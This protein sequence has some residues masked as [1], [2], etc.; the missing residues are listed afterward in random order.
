MVLVTMVS[1]VRK[2]LSMVYNLMK[3]A[4]TRGPRG[5]WVDCLSVRV[6]ERL[7]EWLFST[8]PG[9]INAKPV[10]A[11]VKEYFGSF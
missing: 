9:L 6:T 11:V 8:E 1:V 2:F 7:D 4:H 3:R 5:A 10:S